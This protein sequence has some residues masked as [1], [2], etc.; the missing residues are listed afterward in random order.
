VLKFREAA[1][2]EALNVFNSGVKENSKEREELLFR[3]KSSIKQVKGQGA[4]KEEAARK[5]VLTLFE[6]FGVNSLGYTS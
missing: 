1:P 3:E 2:L 5:V 6:R 4:C